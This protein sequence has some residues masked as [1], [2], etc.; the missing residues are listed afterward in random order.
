M[1]KQIAGVIP[2][3]HTP[4]DD[5][6][7]I[8]ETDLKR[9]IDWAF[10]QGAD[11]VC[12]GMVSEILRLT[13]EE[14]IQLT[15]RMV[16]FGDGR[17]IVIASVGAESTKQAIEYARAAERAGCDAIM[18]IPPISTALPNAE[19]F[20]YFHS[21]ARAVDLPLIVQDASAYVGKAIDLKVHLQ[22]LEEYGLKK[23]MFKPEAAPLG[24][25]LSA[26]RDA[27]GGRAHIFEGSGGI[28]LVDSYRRGVAGTIPG[29]DLLD[30]IVAL[31]KALNAGDEERT[32][33][34]YLPI[35]AMVALQMQA[36]LD[37]FL[38]IEKYLLVKRGIF[39]SERR[40]GPLAWRL[41]PETAAEVDRLF[42]RMKLA[43]DE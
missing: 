41:D 30:G 16:E 1:G 5:E 40:R 26:L 23:I 4:F 31:W 21:L 11:G 25:N 10:D 3:V 13:G 34:L 32:Y 36:G 17:G 38:A 9:E 20:D 28:S 8:N 6:D 42:A 14:R 19:V 24:P 2:V 22:L 35:C 7:C 29:M 18:A 43:L 12:T 39:S 37:G 15:S 33:R 27:T